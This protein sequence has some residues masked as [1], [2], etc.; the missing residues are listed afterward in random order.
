MRKQTEVG[1]VEE[2][3]KREWESGERQM[4]RMRR[5]RGRWE[6]GDGKEGNLCV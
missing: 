4:E 2:K 1:G 3:G 5:Y 6:E